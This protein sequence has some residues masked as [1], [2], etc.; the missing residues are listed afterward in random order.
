MNFGDFKRDCSLVTFFGFIELL[1]LIAFL[2]KT[3]EILQHLFV[4]G[5]VVLSLFGGNLQK[6]FLLHSLTEKSVTL[7][8]ISKTKIVTDKLEKICA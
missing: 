3:A 8:K 6:L 1:Q 2:G 5:C 7:L 4:A